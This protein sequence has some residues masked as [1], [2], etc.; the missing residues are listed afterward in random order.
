MGALPVMRILNDIEAAMISR[1][2]TYPVFT[3]ASVL[4][5]AAC[6]NFEPYIYNANEF[7]REHHSFGKEPKDRST[8][9]ICYNK[10]ST[11]PQI[12]KQMAADEC[13]RFGR[14]AHFYENINLIC[15]VSAPA[16]A[17]FWCL[18]PDETAQDR[19]KIINKTFKTAQDRKEK[20][21]ITF[22]IEKKPGCS[23]SR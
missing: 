2:S 14:R 4:W 13:R 23:T 1:I 6:S 7:N 9:E 20:I 21:N 12:L 22:K 10:R 18:C 17:V 16:Q 3:I 5:L 15:S 11:T 8:V 19:M